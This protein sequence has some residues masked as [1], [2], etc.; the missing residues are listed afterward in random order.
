[1][2]QHLIVLE[3]SK[4]VDLIIQHWDF[5]L[6]VAVD[7]SMTLSAGCSNTSR[8]KKK[9]N[10]NMWK[11]LWVNGGYEGCIL[12]NKSNKGRETKPAFQGLLNL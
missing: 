8:R 11:G 6:L 2:I 5:S 10:W 12:R 1:M 7:F 4:N 3:L 9:V